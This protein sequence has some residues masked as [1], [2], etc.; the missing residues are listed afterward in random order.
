MTSVEELTLSGA[1]AVS[2]TTGGSFNAAFANGATI[3]N[4]AAADAKAVTY[5]MGLS[6]VDTT[7]SITSTGLLNA[8]NENLS[9]TTGSGADTVT[10]TAAS[11]V[12]VAG[13]E[14]S[15]MII[16]TAAGND[17]ITYTHGTLAS[18]NTAGGVA[19]DAGTGK[20][21]ISKTGVNDGSAF[22]ISTFTVQDGDSLAASYD[23]ITGFD[24]GTAAIFADSLN[25]D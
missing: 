20:D 24:L 4:A 1:H 21:T 18:D 13:A 15:R 25:F 2:V 6:N 16:N 5:S 10:I 3:T 11:M 12:G 23:E 19:I 7:I 8:A 17:S 22:G 9:V 14:S